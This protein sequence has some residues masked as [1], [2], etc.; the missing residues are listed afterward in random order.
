MHFFLLFFSLPKKKGED[1]ESRILERPRVASP[2]NWNSMNGRKGDEYKKENIVEPFL[3]LGRRIAMWKKDTE[4]VVVN[5]NSDSVWTGSFRVLEFSTSDTR[6]TSPSTTDGAEGNKIA[7][8]DDWL[9]IKIISNGLHPSV[10]KFDGGCA[11]N[12]LKLGADALPELNPRCSSLSGV[13]AH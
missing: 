6:T 8:T 3:C 10:I 7:L 2:D 4:L 5:R 11:R 12:S 13:I 1:R 9:M